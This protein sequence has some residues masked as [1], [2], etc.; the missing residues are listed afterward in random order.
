MPGIKI[1]LVDEYPAERKSFKKLLEHAGHDVVFCATSRD[2]GLK[3]VNF[4]KE[5]GVRVAIINGNLG[6]GPGDGAIVEQ[7]FR[8]AGIKV[9]GLSNLDVIFGDISLRKPVTIE[10]LLKNIELVAPNNL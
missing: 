5:A 7:A 10:E 4:A 8:E 2:E 3:I 6:T 1:A 9:I